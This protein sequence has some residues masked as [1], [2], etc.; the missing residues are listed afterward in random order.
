MVLCFSF[1]PRSQCGHLYVTSSYEKPYSA[2]TCGRNALNDGERK[3]S[4]NQNLTLL[5]VC[6]MTETHMRN[7]MRCRRACES[8]N[9]DEEGES[10]REPRTS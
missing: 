4:M 6:R 7:A 1:C 10:K 5:L 2:A 8:V 9:V 3:F